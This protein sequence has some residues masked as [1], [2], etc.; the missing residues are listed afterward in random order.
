[1][2]T[3]QV[4]ASGTSGWSITG[5]ATA[6]VSA[7][8]EPP[9]PPSPVLAGGTSGWSITGSA[10]ATVGAPPTPATPVAVAGGTSGWGI[11]GSATATAIVGAP[12]TPATP[13][14]GGTSGWSIT[15]SAAATVGGLA[16]PPIPATPVAG[17]S[18]TPPAAPAPSS[19]TTL[20]AA[21]IYPLLHAW[22]TM[23][24]PTLDADG[25]PIDWTAT[26]DGITEY[27]YLRIVVEG[28]DVTII[29]GIATPFPSWVRGEPFGSQRASI[30]LPQLSPFLA[31]PSWSKFGAN[32]SILLDKINPTT[33]AYMS[34]KSLFEGVLMSM[35]R[36]TPYG[37]LSI[38]ALGSL[39]CADL[40]LHK[41]TIDDKSKDIGT[42]IPALLNS[43]SSRRWLTTLSVV[44]GIQAADTGNWRPTLT[45]KIQNV[46]ATAIK[47]GR[48]WTVQCAVRTPVLVQK[49]MSTV[50]FSMR[51]GQRGVEV[52]LTSDASEAPG[53]I[54]GEGV[55]ADSGYWA[56][57]KYPNWH[58]ETA[59]DFP[60]DDLYDTMQVGR[61]DA[62]T[63]T[64]KGV[65][66]FKTQM[67]SGG[68]KMTTGRSYTQ[69]DQRQVKRF[70]RANGILIDGIVGPQ[71]WAQIF[72]VGGESGTLEG[73][74]ISPLAYST[75]V[76]PN[77]Y[78]SDGSVKGAN[79]DY[80]PAVVLVERFITFGRGVSKTT[81]IESA[82]ET[83][84]R[85]SVPGWYGTATLTMDPSDRSRFEP[86]EGLNW[87]LE[88]HHGEDL[89]LHVAQQ[90]CSENKV[91]LEVDT[92]GRDYPTLQA[93]RARQRDAVDAARTPSR[94]YSESTL[95]SDRARWDSES[96][97]GIMPKHAVFENLF[98]VR[99]LPIWRGGR[100]GRV[101]WETSG[102]A[103]AFVLILFDRQVTAAQILAITGNPLETEVDVISKNREALEA[104][105]MLYA[106]GDG[107]QPAGYWPESKSDDGGATGNPVTGILDDDAS[108]DNY[109]S[110]QWLY[111]ATIASAAC[112]VEG[113]LY[114]IG[115]K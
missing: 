75:E 79:P 99:P 44:T 4:L 22:E 68:Y 66:D 97:A 28:V 35:T 102:P 96:P 63:D 112:D 94:A 106:W 54:Y 23:P 5:S 29:N 17:G 107:K 84:V 9:P 51:S 92:K 10:T 76:M 82:E 42:L 43:L 13:V 74:Y 49:D 21:G 38:D 98:D 34:T 70:Q 88:G 52:E 19:D 85:D 6:T 26:A 110:G 45:G 83:L 89:T 78:T 25:F 27:G 101:R 59:P 62:S 111:A 65:T 60:N 15:G 36:E 67:H 93:V 69:T 113:R 40:Q 80:E 39:F 16:S 18:Q 114:G 32:V 24:V 37:G 14:A 33:R 30:D 2:P 31:L 58:P 81:G 100:V 3:T 72:N 86:L 46:L 8:D 41:P 103:T 61:T 56:N 115:N 109:A 77:L 55:N 20:T 90:S 64:G 50:A 48:Q 11:V 57:W 104:I 71:T 108:F 105:G 1:M 12:P 91:R 7:F 73:A 95:R 87:E 47:G 53:A